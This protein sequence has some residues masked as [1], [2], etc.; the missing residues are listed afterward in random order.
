MVNRIAWNCMYFSMLNREKM[1][2]KKCVQKIKISNIW[3]APP[4]TFIRKKNRCWPILKPTTYPIR[5]INFIKISPA[6]SE[7]FGN[8]HRDTRILYTRLIG[9]VNVHVSNL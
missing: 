1:R 4:L 5:T 6:V 8:K 7:E 9:E 2:T 3:G